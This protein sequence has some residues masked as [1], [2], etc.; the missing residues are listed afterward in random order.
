M[1]N[2]KFSLDFCLKKK[3]CGTCRGHGTGYLSGS[4]IK[5]VKCTCGCHKKEREKARKDFLKKHPNWEKNGKKFS[6]KAAKLILD[7][8]KAHRRTG[9]STL[10]FGPGPKVRKKKPPKK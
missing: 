10:V 7:I 1:P 2:S 3:H 9:K 5:G 8:E 4:P 6:A